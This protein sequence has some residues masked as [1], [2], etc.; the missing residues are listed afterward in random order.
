[1][2]W[3]K[4]IGL[5]KNF[6]MNKKTIGIISLAAVIVLI[7]VVYTVKNSGPKPKQVTIEKALSRTITETSVATGNLEAKYRSNISLD[8]SQKVLKIY[9]QEGQ[10]VKKGDLLLELDSSDYK[11]K[12]DKELIN[13]ENAKLILNQMLETGAAAEKSVS[14]N[15]FSQAKYNLEIAQR[16]YDDFKK[17]YDQSEVLFNSEAIPKSQLDEAKRNLDDAATG[18]KSAEDA[19]KNAENSLKDTNNSSENKIINQRNQITLIQKDIDDYKKRIED[20]KII[21][22]IDGKVIKIG[23]KENQFPVKG[24]EIVVDD[25]SQY[26]TVVNLKQYDALK[27]QKGQKANINIKGSKASYKGTV[28]EIGEFAEAKTTSGGGDD[29]YKVKVS[30]VLDDPKEEVKAGYEADVQFIFQEKD[31]CIAIGFDGIKEDKATGEKYVFVMDASNK[32][33]KRYI[34]TG[35]ESEYYLEITEGLEEN[36][37]YVLNPPESLVEGDLVVQGTSSKTSASQK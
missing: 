28:T 24:D 7:G 3:Y 23:A 33:S 14:E 2:S 27:V 26:K 10:L 34:K 30:V 29:E 17:K 35:I 15:S 13:L 36:E 19:L 12:L 5:T 4:K 22:N 21:S 6:S 8:S 1:M 32:I 18:V 31:N 20:S 11:I 16:K 37:S 25:V 9:V